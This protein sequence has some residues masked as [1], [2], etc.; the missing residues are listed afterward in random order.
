M[1]N[2]KKLTLPVL[3]LSVAI[4]SCNSAGKESKAPVLNAAD[5]DTTVAPQT[6][7]Y[8]FVNGG[9]MKANPVPS[10]ESRW[11]SFNEV[12]KLRYK[13]LHEILEEAAADTKAEKGSS[14]QKV[15]DFYFSGMD[16]VNLN[17]MGI[18]P[19]KDEMKMIDDI[20]DIK[21]MMSVIAHEQ[22]TGAGP[23]YGIYADQDLMNSNRIVV[24]L[25]Q[26]GL[27]LPERDYYFR[28]DPKSAD[29][30]DKYVKLVSSILQEAGY[31]AKASDEKASMIMKFETALAGKSMNNVQLRDPYASYHPMSIADLQKLNPSVDWKSH[32]SEMGITVDSVIVGQPDFFKEMENQMKKMPLND[33]KDYLKWNLIVSNAGSLSDSL[34]MKSF[35]FYGME[36]NGA[37][38]RKPRWKRVL[39]A[40]DGMIGEA[41][42]QEYV[43]K[44]FSPESKERMNKMIDN[45]LATFKDRIQSNTW[46]SDSTKTKALT[47]LSKI[48]RKI[49]YPDKW[50]DYSALTI[51]RGPYVMNMMRAH[52]F[53][54]NF[55]INKI[56][57]PVDRT[58]WGMTPP[59]VNAYY[60]P[61]NNEIVFP[62][63]ILQP[64]FFDPNADDAINYGGIGAVICHEITHGFDD[65]G[66]QFDGDGNLKMWWTPQDKENFDKLAAKLGNQFKNYKVLDTIPINPG[67]TM[68]E[69]IADLGGA[70]IAYA[71]FMKT[72][73]AKDTNKIEGFT[74]QQRF[75][76]SWT[77]VWRTNTTDAA[78]LSQVRTNP[79]SP[80]I[81]RGIAPIVNMNDF[82][83]AFNIKE[84]DAMY[85]SDTARVVIW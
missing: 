52:E 35:R 39:D 67:L 40:V 83:S 78:M 44:A 21:S 68:G 63:G 82:F 23:V 76:I 46:M 28:P 57:K 51:D 48:T 9:W 58:E 56:G 37:K 77:R 49:A 3:A 34:A 31:D 74:P 2:L 85:K 62:A 13:V 12:G 69:N 75:F 64:P 7:F 30:R 5:F 47:K 79:H 38:E 66:S 16:S 33:W 1:F 15:G 8:K 36:L 11:G 80:G 18:E 26:G 27:G 59:T 72:D 71:A 55:M 6:D 50:K 42:G 73:E 81:I 43:K 24:Y 65:Q 53:S 29:I 41:L 14:R 22:K 25:G 19:L 60:N 4:A 45:M 61:A 17:K 32:L 10:D 20:S 54:F 84:G 70:M